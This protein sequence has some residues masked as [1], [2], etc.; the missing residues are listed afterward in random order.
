MPRVEKTVFISY[1][2][3]NIPWAL[4]IFQDLTQHGSDVFFDYEGMSSGDFEQVI[5]ENI[6]SRAHFLLL[7]TPSALQR[8]DE[9]GDWL[10]REIETALDG[11]RNIVPL[12]LEGFNFK[13]SAISDKLTGKL[14]LVKQ[15]NG[16]NIPP[17][18]FREA[19]DRLRS[20]FLN[21]PLDSVLHPASA[22]ARKVATRQKTAARR[23]NAVDEEVLT[24]QQLFEH[25]EAANDDDE[26]LRL[27]SEAIRIDPAFAQAYRSRGLLRAKLDPPTALQDYNE[28]I[29]LNRDDEDSLCLRGC[30]RITLGDFGGA[31][32][33]LDE[34]IRLRPGF[35]W[36]VVQRGIA[37]EE[38]GD[39]EGAIED[40]GEAIRLFDMVPSLSLHALLFRAR[41]RRRNGDLKEAV[42]DYDEVT[43]RQPD[44]GKAFL[45]RAVARMELG[46]RTGALQDVEISERLGYKG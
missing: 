26:R 3:T 21:V 14:A 12:F 39:I 10:R 18:Y 23:A 4:A 29:R 33:D 42:R 32:E 35:G 24:A 8:C 34:A 30:L 40:F 27:Y 20:R 31:I 36:A 5:L 38:N 11:R 15:Y 41:A 43:R 1:R 25:G 16:L 2:R 37:R 44:N 45:E 7:L 6:R 17:E 19:M 28:A 46:D 13:T 22:V 9:P